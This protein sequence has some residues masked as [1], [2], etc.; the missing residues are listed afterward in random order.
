[1]IRRIRPVVLVATLLAALLPSFT[2]AQNFGVSPAE[3]RIDDLSPGEEAEF[4]FAI[5]NKDDI[6]HTFTVTTYSP[7]E[8]ER[9]EGRAEFPDDSWISFSPEE[10]EVAANSKGTVRVTVAIPS[11]QEWAGKNWEVWIR[12]AP[13]SMDLLVANCYIRFLVSTSRDVEAGPKTALIVGIVI[14][15]LLLGYGAYYFRRKA[16]SK[17]PKR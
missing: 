16:K 4:E 5:R 15:I 17:H 14:G 2:L 10:I 11:N 6:S 8:P 12:V 1:M 9:R 7:E 3:V 13:E